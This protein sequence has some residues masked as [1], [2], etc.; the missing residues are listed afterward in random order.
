[1]AS[2]SHA[3]VTIRVQDRFHGYYMVI[4]AEECKAPWRLRGKAGVHRGES[5]GIE[6]LCSSHRS[7]HEM[8]RKH[9]SVRSVVPPI[10]IDDYAATHREHC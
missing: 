8:T 3:G 5:G 2:A 4:E 9:G 1:M 6:F 7:E 10:V